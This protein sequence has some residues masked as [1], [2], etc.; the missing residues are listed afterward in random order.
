MVRK[1]RRTMGYP[2]YLCWFGSGWQWQ[3]CQCSYSHCFG[4]VRCVYGRVID[5]QRGV[6]VIVAVGGRWP[7]LH[8]A[9][10]LIL[11]LLIRYPAIVLHV[12]QPCPTL[13]HIPPSSMDPRHQHHHHHHHPVHHCCCL[14]C[15]AP[16]PSSCLQMAAD[17]WSLKVSIVV[18]V[19]KFTVCGQLALMSMGK[20][21]G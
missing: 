8:P 5:T 7:D 19:C 1:M 4:L 14:S 10:P 11:S 18:V 20:E 9:P 16:I 6:A 21:T 12:L 13:C 2:N 15:Y 3:S 17:S